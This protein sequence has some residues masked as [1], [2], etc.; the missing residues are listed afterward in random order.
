MA[1]LITQYVLIIFLVLG[2]AYLIYL[3]DNRDVIAYDDYFGIN[4]CILNNLVG[5]E[6][7]SENVKKII[8]IVSESVRYV[9]IN[10]KDEEN[11]FKEEKA[12][13]HARYAINSLNLS[14]AIEDESIRYIIRIASACL[15]P[16]NKVF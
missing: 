13:S 6:A 2:F 8:R 12:L 10:Y 7:T 15:P 14:S 9:E 11:S 3:L 16:T 5:D 4:Y 1:Q